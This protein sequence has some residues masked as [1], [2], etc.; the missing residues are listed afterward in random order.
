M[1]ELGYENVI[2]VIFSKKN[3]GTMLFVLFSLLFLL[4]NFPLSSICFHLF[5][6][7]FYKLE[8]S[9]PGGHTT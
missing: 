9:H 4:T 7:C 3:D 6:E 1:L 5:K 2:T 8:K